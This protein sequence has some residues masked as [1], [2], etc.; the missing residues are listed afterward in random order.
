[1]GD[2]EDERPQARVAAGDAGQFRQDVHEHIL[3][4]GLG[5]IHPTVSEVAQDGRGYGDVYGAE[6]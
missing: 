4:Q 5:V 2:G 1:M 6:T 3:G